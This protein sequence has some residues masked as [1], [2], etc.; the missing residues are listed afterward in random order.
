MIG[1]SSEIKMVGR[2][3]ELEELKNHLNKARDG[4]GNT[5]FITGEAG[6]GKTR[7]LEEL[8]GYARE[9]G[10]DVL[11]GWS[12]YESFTPY[13]PFLE[14]LRSGGLESLFAD[15][16]PRVEAVYLVSHSGLSIKEV[17]RKETKL[18]PDIF[19]GMLTAVGDFVKDSLSMLTGK[20]KKGS[21][22]TV[23]YENYRILIE[24]RGY[25]NLAVI[26][27]GRENE[28]LVNDIK[29]ILGNVDE[30]FG[31]L[32]KS[33]DGNEKSIEGIQH[34]LE[35]LITSGKY[36]GIDYAKNDAKIKRNRLFENILLGLERH[37]KD[38]PSLLCIEDLQ[39]AD[40]SSLV[41]MHYVARNTRKCNLLILGSYRPEDVSTIKDGEV[42][43]LIETMQMMNREDLLQ[44]IELERLKKEQVDELI[45]SFFEKTNFSD[46]FSAHLFKETEGNP[47]F[48]KS[49]IRMLI[50]EGTIVFKDEKWIL[51]KEL[52]KANIPSKIYDV[53]IRRLYRV[54][55]KQREILEYAAVMGEDFSSEVL[56]HTTRLNKIDLL[57]ELRVLEQNHRLIHSTEPRYKFDHVKIKEVISSQIPADLKK[58]Y[59]E[60]IAEAIWA[61]NKDHQDKVMGDLAFHF[62]NCAHKDRALPFLYKAAERAKIDYS[63]EEAINLYNKA[64]ELE[65]DTHKR[66]EMFEVIGDIYYSIGDYDKSME[67]YKH[68]LESIK[69]NKKMAEIK[70]KIGVIYYLKLEYE[71]SLKICTEALNLVKDEESK[72]KALA[73]NNIGN[74][75]WLRGEYDNAL[76]HYEESLEIWRKIDDQ[77]GIAQC[78]FNIGGV[79]F[80]RE[81]YDRALNFREKSLEISEKI[82]D[83]F[84]L[85]YCYISVGHIYDH[86]GDYER[87]LNCFEKGVEIS[88]KIGNQR[89][90][91][92]GF[93]GTAEVYFKK[94]NLEKALDICNR[95]FDLSEKIGA[96]DVIAIT[97][98]TFGMIYREQKKWKESI[99]SFEKAIKN[100]MVI[101]DEMIISPTIFELG[102]T[103]FE[104]GLMWKAKGDSERAKEHFS[105][106]YNIYKKLKLEKQ[107]EKVITSIDNL[108]TT[109]R[110]SV[111][112]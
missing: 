89:F 66:E 16:I 5:V 83:S 63:N 104:F 31:E 25:L 56:M 40:P 20:E 103:H 99:E 33:W 87:A 109:S 101:Q 55:E 36:D 67:S 26:L 21:L 49:L 62:Y 86:I 57:N 111:I 43:H 78:L 52:M 11:T 53:V 12:M 6:V 10:V 39:W 68:T 69:G 81:K 14:A 88:R 98:R 35:P 95:A 3:K 105:E 34:T 106:A 41:L 32:L 90:M 92:Y 58:E 84:N 64:L 48:I 75:H 65:K 107:A 47:F 19:S 45:S 51:T 46:E 70:T 91:T 85:A 22:N 4:Q 37:V 102:L 108:Q 18:D 15:E 110:G 61:M 76:K 72:E 27:I 59:H 9:Q 112:P 82:G 60:A 8:K 7:L 54:K 42:H 80:W 93:W 24:N 100:I 94:K 97:M 77:Q 44:K 1:I 38:T 79:H 29:R 30:Q 73:I 13:M 74:V 28:F 71:K 17:I 23:G 50:E 96:E 2:T